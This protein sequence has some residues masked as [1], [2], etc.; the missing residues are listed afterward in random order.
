MRE[1]AVYSGPTG[2]INGTTTM[3]DEG[4]G[5]RIAADRQPRGAGMFVND[6]RAAEAEVM[7]TGAH[8]SPLMSDGPQQHEHGHAGRTP[9]A[10]MHNVPIPHA[11][12]GRH[13]N[14]DSGIT[15]LICLMV[16]NVPPFHI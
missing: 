4:G 8:P 15:L 13:H 7:G 3:G 1:D 12:P 16:V 2:I 14:K 5:Q 9:V 6:S 10:G 11:M